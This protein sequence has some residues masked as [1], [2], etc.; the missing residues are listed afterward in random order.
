MASG[1]FGL[2]LKALVLCRPCFVSARELPFSLRA[3]TVGHC[4]C[5]GA[6]ASPSKTVKPR[7]E[8]N[9]GKSREKSSPWKKLDANGL[10]IRKSMIP[11]SARMVLNKLKKKGFQ[12]YLVGG[13]VRDL[14][15][16]RIPKDFDI[17]TTAE[18]KQVRKVF[19]SCL[20]VGKRFP[21]CHVHVDDTIVEVSSF[22]TSAKSSKGF[23]NCLK[24]PP[25]CNEIDYA[26]WRNC[27]QRDFTI[28]GLMFD[29]SEN[30]V[31]DYIGGVEDIR[32]SQV[33]TV[34]PARLSFV[35]DSA[36]I[37]RAI[38]IAAR[39]GFGFTKDVAVSLKEL[40]SSL[41]RLDK[42][43]VLMEMNYMMAYGS[44]EASLRLL[45]RFGLLEVLL[46]IQASYFVSQGFRRRDGRSNMLLSL[47][48]N[49][50]R[51][52]APDRP[53]PTLL[54]IGILAF[55]KALVDQPR[56]PIVV[57]AFCLT[58]FNEGSLSE[59]I[60]VTK[61]ITQKHN[62]EFRELSAR[63]TDS[64][65]DARLSKQVVEFAESVRSAVRKMK[66][67]DY[68]SRAMREYPQAPESDLVLMSE[69]LSER[70]MRIFAC[71]RRG[72]QERCCKKRREGRIDYKSL[73]L[74]D[75]QETRRVLARIAFDT[76]YPPPP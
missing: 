11:E 57:A 40:S 71:V 64:D 49:L 4:G 72:N 46:P 35:E 76:V 42:T 1:S 19:P 70:V 31:Y 45:W 23:K 8:Q 62:S 54:W 16:D 2:S 15:L 75:L 51:L 34:C 50:D 33:K 41:L 44:A 7:K 60:D 13:C 68:I 63:R 14:I 28:N 67:R 29:P 53:C 55:H 17:I 65:S 27:I 9:H 21:I 58:L 22:S 39:L 26:R 59:S 38:R 66:D 5:V 25:G 37:L 69:A 73:A 48:R 43:R 36:R 10:G 12:V 6:V 61:S 47:F 56:D 52:V 32:N 18:L 3:H 24:R 74:G 30:V 20:I